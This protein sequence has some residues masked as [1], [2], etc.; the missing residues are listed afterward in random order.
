MSLI[1]EDLV[2]I[3]MGPSRLGSEITDKQFNNENKD[4]VASE[5]HYTSR[6]LYNVS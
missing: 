4:I 6:G 5:S 2:S 1:K 3:L